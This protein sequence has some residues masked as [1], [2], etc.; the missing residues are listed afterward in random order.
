M[1]LHCPH[2]LNVGH[3]ERLLPV[4]EEPSAEL[5]HCS[6]SCR[7]STSMYLAPLATLCHLTAHVSHIGTF[8]ADGTFGHQEAV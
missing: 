3:H 8:V 6:P 7:A 1:H 4:F 2:K 5:Q